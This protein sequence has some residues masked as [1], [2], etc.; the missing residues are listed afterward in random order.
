MRAREM[1]VSSSK[2]ADDASFR[3]GLT[4]GQSESPQKEAEN[5][6]Y[7][8]KDTSCGFMLGGVF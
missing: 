1:R 8:F 6:L 3:D 2:G 7:P 5:T 4:L